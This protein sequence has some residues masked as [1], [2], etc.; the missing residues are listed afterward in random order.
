M[1]RTDEQGG[2]KREEFKSERVFSK[3][4][5]RE[6]SNLTEEPSSRRSGVGTLF[7]ESIILLVAVMTIRCT[8][9]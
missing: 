9:R 2:E 1:Q 6:A 5:D 3:A 8:V 4:A 7:I